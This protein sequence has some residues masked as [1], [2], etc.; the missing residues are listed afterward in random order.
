[1]TTTIYANYNLLGAE[2]RTVYSTAR[3]EI[4]DELVV[5]IPDDLFAGYNTYGEVLVDVGLSYAHP[6]GEVLCGND[7]PCI[8]CFDGDGYV[9]RKL[10]V[11]GDN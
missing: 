11:V 7:V 9:L 4:Y 5:D 1:M 3:G 10:S 6:L 8:R 2:N